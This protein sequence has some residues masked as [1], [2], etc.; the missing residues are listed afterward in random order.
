VKNSYVGG[1][2]NTGPPEDR[3]VFMERV[4]WDWFLKKYNI[5]S[6]TQNQNTVAQIQRLFMILY[7]T[8]SFG[9]NFPHITISLDLIQSDLM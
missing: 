5:N 8:T 7:I 6:V 9:K 1:C 2:D 3:R 4:T